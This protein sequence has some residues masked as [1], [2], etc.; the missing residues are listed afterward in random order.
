VVVD[1]ARSRDAQVVEALAGGDEVRELHHAVA[2]FDDLDRLA[3]RDAAEQ[4]D[5]DGLRVIAA[6]LIGEPASDREGLLRAAALHPA[7]ALELLDVGLGGRARDAELPAEPLVGRGD[8]L[9]KNMS[10]DRSLGRY[11]LVG[12]RRRRGAA[13]L[14]L[15]LRGVFGRPSRARAG[16]ETSRVGRF[17][18]GLYGMVGAPRTLV[19]SSW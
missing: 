1:H 7:L 9:A 16:S 2:S 15:R 11:L 17:E 10:L 5:R 4:A 6:I 18:N 19:S 13:P 14:R 8:S 12:E 3:R